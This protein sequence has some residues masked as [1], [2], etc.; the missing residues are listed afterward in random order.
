MKKYSLASIFAILLIIT[1]CSS[2]S[3]NNSNANIKISPPGWIQ[4]TWLDESQIVGF[5]FTNNDIITINFNT[6]QSQREIL[7]LGADS[8]Q[9]VSASD[10]S[11]SNYYSVVLNFPAGQ[12]VTYS[13]NKLSDNE[14]NWTTISTSVF[15]KQ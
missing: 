7:K 6:E 4:G 12:T 9:T 8:G 14:I 11:T 5:K 1:S 3:N 2:D 13:F 15:I 10:E